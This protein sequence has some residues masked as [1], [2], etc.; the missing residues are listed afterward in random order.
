MNKPAVEQMRTID[1]VNA[2]LKQRYN[3]ECRFRR[4]GLGAVLLGLLFVGLMFL[5]IIGNGYSAFQQT[6]ILLEIDYRA[7]V[8]DPTGARDPATLSSADYAAL[9]KSSLRA[10]FPAVQGRGEKR[11]LYGMLSS[12]AF[13]ELRRRVMADP[14]LIGTR[15]Q[16]WLPVDDDIDMLVKG[17]IDRR[18]PESER[19]LDNRV[20]AWVEQLESTGA[21]EKQFNLTF[22]TGG[23]SREPELAGIGGA[24]MGSLYTLIVTLLLSFPIGVAAAVYLE[25]FAPRNRWT[26]LV[27]VNINNLAAVPSIVFGL[28]G[29]AVFINFFGLPRSAPLVG[30]MVLTLMTLPTIIIASR[31]ALKSVP[32]SIREAAL[33][34]GASRMQTVFHHVLPLAMPGMLTGT[35]IGMAQALGETAPLL[36][37]GMVAFIVDIPGGALDP[38]TVLPVQIFLWAD[39]PERAFM[40]KT[41][42]AIM[43][44]LGFL[45]LMNVIAVI[46]RKRFERRW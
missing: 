42:A 44:L 25:E 32:P 40:E 28:L 16:L 43:V 5:N 22:L 27:E 6:R 3:R 13:L 20:V 11:E 10:L 19:R 17:Y 8:I 15:E 38:S 46:L 1:R 7:E 14:G 9:V 41:S 36:M 21:I 23:D 33:G 45:I 30:G 31:A 35:I 12:G 2:T 24:V 29:L 39:S 18:L 26:D 4:F 37:I 34:V